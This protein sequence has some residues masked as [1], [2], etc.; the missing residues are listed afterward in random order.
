M[1]AGL[2]GAGGGGTV[3]PGLMLGLARGGCGS[4]REATWEGGG[5]EVGGGGG[6]GGVEELT[7]PPSPP[8][9]TPPR[10]LGVCLLELDWRGE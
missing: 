5:V 1:A 10:R 2:R 8:P 9:P 6:G 4:E 7:C 3:R